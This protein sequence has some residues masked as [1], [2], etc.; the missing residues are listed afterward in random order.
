MIYSCTSTRTKC[1]YFSHRCERGIR[2]CDK[3]RFECI[4]EVLSLRSTGWFFE[5]IEGQ[6]NPK[7]IWKWWERRRLVYNA[8][9]LLTAGWSFVAFYYFCLNSGKLSPGE[10]V[11]EPI[12]ILFGM[13]FGPVI[14]NLAYFLGP[15]VDSVLYKPGDKSHRGP[16]LM[17]LGI[18]FSL[19]ILC[20]PS[21]YWFL[22][23]AQL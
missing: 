1:E 10:D 6:V 23:Y 5:P 20:L 12:G 14:W 2:I 17:E 8:I 15:I 18:R 16:L 19:A 13:V 22:E 4:Y 11:E 9:V 7:S 3:M 21:V